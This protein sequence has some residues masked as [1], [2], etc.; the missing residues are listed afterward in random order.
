[1]KK[2]PLSLQEVAL[3]ISGTLDFAPPLK[4]S[5][6]EGR[7]GEAAERKSAPLRRHHHRRRPGEPIPLALIVPDRVDNLGELTIGCGLAQKI[8]T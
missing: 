6:G 4:G 2:R 3:L 1:M 5:E 8:L 7:G